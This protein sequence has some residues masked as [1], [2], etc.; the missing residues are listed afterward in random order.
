[1]LQLAQKSDVH[2]GQVTNPRPNSV[3]A[4]YRYRVVQ[5]APVLQATGSGSSTSG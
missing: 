5:A 1:M 3:P 4:V 2:H